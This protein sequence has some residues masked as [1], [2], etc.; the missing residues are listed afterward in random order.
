MTQISY[1]D[2]LS[3]GFSQRFDI[4][5]DEISEEAMSDDQ[6]GHAERNRKNRNLAHKK[7]VSFEDKLRSINAKVGRIMEEGWL[8]MRL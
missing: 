8:Q 2:V 4:E 7:L 3:R 6:N 5:G 1:N